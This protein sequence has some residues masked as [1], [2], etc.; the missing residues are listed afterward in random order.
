M[1]AGAVQVDEA[2]VEMEFFVSVVFAVVTDF[3]VV[4]VPD[5]YR[6]HTTDAVRLWSVSGLGE[7][8]R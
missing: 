4:V 3:D 5:Q 1:S 7:R 2:R 6:G 8:A